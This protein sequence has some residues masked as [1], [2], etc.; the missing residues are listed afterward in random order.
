MAA[1]LVY[2]S[3]PKASVSSIQLN[4]NPELVRTVAATASRVAT[5]LDADTRTSSDSYEAALMAAGAAIDG[6]KRLERG[7]IDNGFCLVRPPGHHAESN[8]AMGFCLFNTLA[9]ATK[10]AIRHL[11]LH[12][13]MIVDWDLHHGNGTQKSFYRNEKVLY[14]SYHQFPFYPGTGALAE[15]GKGRGWG[16]T[17][18]IPLS[19]GHGDL[20]FARI[21]NDIFIPLAN[22]SS[23][24]HPC[25]LRF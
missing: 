24:A 20:E 23:P 25:F 21:F 7:E 1:Q 14:C 4:H 9:V 17:V 13:I 10:W 2:P 8:R 18:N 16:D 15:S 6:I 22:L 5:F 19:T 11:G 3:F 12:R